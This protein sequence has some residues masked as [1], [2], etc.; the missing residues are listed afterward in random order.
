MIEKKVLKELRNQVSQIK[1]EIAADQKYLL[2]K[3][4]RVVVIEQEIE[5]LEI[6][7]FG[8]VHIVDN[9]NT[10]AI[11]IYKLIQNNNMK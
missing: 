7:L 8:N 4:N 2:V 6:E 3:E 1:L 5:Q 11:R 10:A 9:E